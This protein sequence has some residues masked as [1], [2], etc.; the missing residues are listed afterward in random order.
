MWEA[1]V[2]VLAVMTLEE[3]RS[4]IGRDVLYC[5][6]YRSAC[7]EPQRAVILEVIG[8]FVFIRS[9]GQQRVPARPEDLTLLAGQDTATGGSAPARDLLAAS[10]ASLNEIVAV[11]V[12]NG[13]ASR[14]QAENAFNALRYHSWAWGFTFEGEPA[15][16]APW[17]QPLHVAAIRK[18]RW[19]EAGKR[20]REN[21]A[22]V[23]AAALERGLPLKASA[24]DL[25]RRAGEAALV[26]LVTHADLGAA[27]IG[28]SDAPGSRIAEHRRAGWQLIAAFQVTAKAAIA[29]EAEVL[30]W[31]RRELGL[32]SYLSRGQ[33]PQGGWTETVAAGSIDLPATVTRICNL[34][35]L[36]P[37]ADLA[38]PR[39]RTLPPA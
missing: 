16:G 5:S 15:S 8:S 34:A 6:L 31:W 4:H 32:P 22:Q 2:S 36:S 39:V 25:Q 3:A 18:T 1:G 30:R 35:V 11:I 19:L 33:M 26:Y 21:L 24:L 13:P 7:G 12:R 10:Q 9:S 20:Y 38:G 17:D 29:I 23:E 37:A 28:V 14:A 27:K